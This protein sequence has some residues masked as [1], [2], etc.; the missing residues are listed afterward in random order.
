MP[1][2]TTNGQQQRNVS[3]KQSLAICQ[4]LQHLESEL[5]LRGLHVPR[6][7][8]VADV[9]KIHALREQPPAGATTNEER[10]IFDSISEM[11]IKSI[12]NR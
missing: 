12:F 4:H 8:Y 3:A 5:R 11:A 9:L 6:P 2:A 10:I 7:K 1:P